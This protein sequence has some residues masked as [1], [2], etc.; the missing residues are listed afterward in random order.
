[1]M[2]VVEVVE[3]SKPDLLMNPTVPTPTRAHC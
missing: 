1:M 3:E 2:K